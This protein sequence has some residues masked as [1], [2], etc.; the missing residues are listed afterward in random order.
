MVGV[1]SRSDAVIQWPCAQ[2]RGKGR[3]S[4]MACTSA[5]AS[6][7]CQRE[8]HLRCAVREP[9]EQL[10]ECVRRVLLWLF[11]RNARGSWRAAGVCGGGGGTGGGRGRGRDRL[12]NTAR[13]SK[14]AGKQAGRQA[15]GQAGKQDTQKPRSNGE[16]VRNDKR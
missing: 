10:L 5:A 6:E 8:Q 1:Y 16:G 13:I 11:E 14:Q 9:L 15:G 3:L 2:G 7:A 12:Q 4:R